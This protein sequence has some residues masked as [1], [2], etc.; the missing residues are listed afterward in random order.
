MR[1]H[2]P[3]PR[4]LAGGR[5]FTDLTLALTLSRPVKGLLVYLSLNHLEMVLR[6]SDKGLLAN[7][8]ADTFGAITISILATPGGREF[9]EI[10]GGAFQK[11]STE[12]INAH[13]A[14][15]GE[16]ASLDQLLPFFVE[17]GA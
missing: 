1:G 15:G 17:K 2:A 5:K 6:M 9:W 10:G 13:L 4:T 14:T 8:T 12:Y 7:D 11:F 3:D 16:L